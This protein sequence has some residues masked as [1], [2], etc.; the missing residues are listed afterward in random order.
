MSSMNG[1]IEPTQGSSP[2]EHDSFPGDIAPGST[3]L[4]AGSV[5][6]A[7]KAV[8]LNALARSGG[9]D[10]IALVVTTTDSAD[11]TASTYD[12]I[13]QSSAAPSLRLVDTTSEGQSVSALYEKY[14][15]VF[16]PSPGDLERLVIGLSDL[17]A[18]PGPST[19][20]RH[21]VIRSLSPIMENASV[22]DVCAVLERISGLRTGTGYTFFGLDYTAHDEE[23]IRAITDHVDVILWVTEHSD[24][25]L[26][27]EVRP[28]PGRH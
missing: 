26:D 18:M 20:A 8:G 1:A 17:T 5:D 9:G 7:V 11:E 15:V 27:F 12:T 23:T 22:E 19:G 3:V 25:A 21:L 6:P 16:V 4:V 13:C 28:V 10:D 2:I 14:P 24:G